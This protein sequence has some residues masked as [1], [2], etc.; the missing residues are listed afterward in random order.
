MDADAN[1]LPLRI[2]I[3]DDHPMVRQVIRFA[4]EDRAT[5]EVVGE[6]ASGMEALEQYALLNP[7]V[8][9]LDLGLPDIDGL[10]VVRQLKQMGSPVRILVITGRDDPGA[11]LSALMER[12]DGYLEKTSSIEHI[13]AAIEAVGSGTQ[14]FS[15][16]HRRDLQDEIGDIARR[17]RA[18]ARAASALSQ[19][20]R[21]ILGFISQGRTTR[22]MARVLGVS[23]RTAESHISSLYQKLNVRTRVQALHRAAGLGLVELR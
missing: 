16:E 14:V 19:R 12:V 7:D 5:L 9:V 13:G 22:Q 11:V 15:M 17:M 10:E 20:E 21:E 23:E 8:L 2:L 18:A 1:A 3:V 4:C 6:A